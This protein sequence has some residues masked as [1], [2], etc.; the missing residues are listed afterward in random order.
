MADKVTHLRQ[1]KPCPICSKPSVQ[2][3]HPYCSVRCADVD[4]N[5]WLKGT[6]VIPGKPADDADESEGLF[7]LDDQD[8]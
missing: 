4:L 3:Y 7:D 5:R 2:A 6:Y 8:K 1:P